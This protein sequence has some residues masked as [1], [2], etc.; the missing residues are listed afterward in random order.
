MTWHGKKVV[1][2][3]LS[4]M[5]IGRNKLGN[6]QLTRGY[7]TGRVLWGALTQQLTRLVAKGPATDSP[8]YCRMGKR[9]KKELAYTYFYPTRDPGGAVDLW[10]WDAR[11]AR[12]FLGTYASTALSYPSNS[13]AE[14]L[15][16]E[17]EFISPNDLIDGAP[18][19]LSGYVF[20]RDGG[21]P[22][23][24]VLSR[25][26]L[27]GERGYG[28]GRVRLVEAPRL[29]KCEKLFGMY[30]YKLDGDRPSLE[31][32]GEAT[33][34]AHTCAPEGD[35]H[36]LRG[37]MEPLVGRETRARGR[38]GQYL[39]E[40]AICYTPGS[41]SKSGHKYAIEAHGIWSLAS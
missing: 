36:D 13:A 19:Y 17:V 28:W 35:S 21:P 10:P 22:W 26:Q 27:G 33:L 20:V 18:V 12:R 34:L 15:L 31:S 40:A 2:R 23:E 39:S 32:E 38:S 7:V 3:L 16:H 24:K 6:L 30:A 1:L 9:V 5:H 25:I 14:G 4:P 11:Y 41:R 37:E 8:A 29:K